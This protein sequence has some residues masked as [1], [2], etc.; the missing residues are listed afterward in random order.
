MHIRPRLL[1]RDPLRV[2]GARCDLAV[3]RD[4][5]LARE[6]RGALYDPVV[7]EDVQLGALRL[8]HA[9]NDLDAR[10]AEQNESP[11]RMIGKGVGGAHDHAAH[12]RL[13]DQVA[14][15]SGAAVGGAGLQRHIQR[16]VRF[17][18]STQR[19][20]SHTLGVRSAV[21]GVE[22][23]GHDHPVLDDHGPYHGIRRGPAPTPAGEVEG[24]S[25]KPFVLG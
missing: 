9:R 18:R 6:Q 13:A 1:A 14:A 2:G 8:Q 12:A 3:E 22:T 25:H 10:L 5:R 16:G 19:R 17:G 23:L 20:E 4:R 7:E 11:A 24:A 21:F 15:G